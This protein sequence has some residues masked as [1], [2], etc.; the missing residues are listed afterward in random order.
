MSDAATIPDWLLAMRALTGVTEVSGSGDSAKILAMR[1]R[2]AK[3]WADTPGMAA[4]CALYQ[5]DAT[6]WCASRWRMPD[7][8]GHL[9]SGQRT[10]TALWAQD[11]MTRMGRARD[12]GPEQS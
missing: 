4:Y 12:R 10:P 3:R 8:G 6:P 11:G 1:D 9:R 7:L 5:H 2:I